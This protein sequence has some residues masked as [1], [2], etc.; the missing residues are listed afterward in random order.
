MPY[1]TNE[2]SNALYA[3]TNRPNTVDQLYNACKVITMDWTIADLLAIENPKGLEYIE[4]AI[5]AHEDERRGLKSALEALRNSNDRYRPTEAEA[6]DEVSN[7]INIIG[8]EN[9]KFVAKLATEHRTL[10]QTFTGI[11]LNWLAHLSQLSEYE[12]DA[13]NEYS[14][15]VAKKIA[16]AL[17]DDDQFRLSDRTPC[18]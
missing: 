5:L 1:I 2:R 9:K 13:L 10:Q 12:Y 6:A 7:F 3:V 15:R 16:K 8:F 17:E 4:N 18:I 11:C 14:V